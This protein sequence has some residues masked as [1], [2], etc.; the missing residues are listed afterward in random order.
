ME[1]RASERRSELITEAVLF[2]TAIV[3]GWAV[4]RYSL[5]ALGIEQRIYQHLYDRDKHEMCKGD[6]K[7]MR[8]RFGVHGR[9]RV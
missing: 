3:V 8:E 1:C 5:R 4:A 9:R 2:I 7:H 6:R